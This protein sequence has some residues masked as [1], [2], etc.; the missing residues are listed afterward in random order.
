MPKKVLLVG[1]CGADGSY[2]R[3]AVRAAAGEAAVMAADDEDSLNAALGGGVDLIL[4]NRVLGGF[5]PSGGVEQI[6]R[7]RLSNPDVKL[8]LVSNYPEAQAAAIAAGALPGFGK[9][10]IGKPAAVTA[11]KNAL[12]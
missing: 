6:Q 7:L 2:L 5:E 12:K 10:D 9:R 8:M 4:L 1:H 11:L 3:S